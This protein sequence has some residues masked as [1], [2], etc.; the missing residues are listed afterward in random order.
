MVEVLRSGE[1]YMVV[2]GD[3]ELGTFNH[4]LDAN[5]FALQLLEREIAAS[6]RLISGLEIT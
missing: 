4:L 5:C 6:V 2:M 1:R 3:D